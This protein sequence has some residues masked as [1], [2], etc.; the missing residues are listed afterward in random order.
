MLP[1]YFHDFVITM[2]LDHVVRYISLLLR[3]C[4]NASYPS[5][6]ISHDPLDRMAVM[7]CQTVTLREHALADD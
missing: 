7:F 3:K 5:H 4:S 1:H 2:G 6:N